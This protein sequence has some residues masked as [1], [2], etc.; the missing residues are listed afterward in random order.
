M[1]EWA[2]GRV[3]VMAPDGTW[4]GRIGTTGTKPGQYLSP[5]FVA[6]SPDEQLYVADERPG[7]VLVFRLL[8]S[9]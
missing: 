3:Q 8:P 7:R 9:P 4:L 6:I 1:A 5:L 2:G